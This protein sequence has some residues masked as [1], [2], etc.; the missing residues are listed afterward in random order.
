MSHCFIRSSSKN[1]S[2]EN[3]SAQKNRILPC[4]RTV[5]RN[6]QYAKRESV[7]SSIRTSRSAYNNIINNPN[8]DF[9]GITFKSIP[10]IHISNN[11]IYECLPIN[12]IVAYL[13]I[14]HDPNVFYIY[15]INN[16]DSFYI[17]NNIL[18]T[19]KIF[20]YD[21]NN[22]ENNN[23]DIH[24]IAYKC[25][26]GTFCQT[27]KKITTIKISNSQY[28]Q[29]ILSICD[30]E[31]SKEDDLL[32]YLK[33]IQRKQIKLLKS[34]QWNNFF[35][36][37]I[38]EGDYIT[39]TSFINNE[40]QIYKILITTIYVDQN[41][42]EYVI[43]NIFH[44][45]LL[46]TISIE[47]EF[48]ESSLLSITFNDDSNSLFNRYNQ[49]F[50]WIAENINGKYVYNILN[51]D[52]TSNYTITAND[53]GKNIVASVV[54]RNNETIVI[55]SKS[56][57]SP[58]ITNI[59]N[60]PTGI[61]KI[62]GY[63]NIGQYLNVNENISDLDGI[64]NKTITWYQG[65]KEYGEI[66]SVIY[67]W[68]I[69]TN[70]TDWEAIE[71]SNN[72]YFSIPIDDNYKNK[73]L[74]I[75]A[76]VY[77]IY[78]NKTI[79]YSSNVSD[80][81]KI[82]EEVQ[83]KVF[84]YSLQGTPLIGETLQVY[85]KDNNIMK[86]DN[87]TQ[88]IWYRSFNKVDWSV[89]TQNRFLPNITLP[90]SQE[91]LYLNNYIKAT[92]VVNDG[93]NI[94][95]YDTNSS[96]MITNYELFNNGTI[97]VS[98]K[99]LEG[100]KLTALL[101]T[102]ESINLDEY[103]VRYFWQTSRDN[104]MWKTLSTDDLYSLQELENQLSYVRTEENQNF[105]VSKDNKSMI[106]PSN[107]SFIDSVVR[108]KVLLTKNGITEYVLSNLTS[109]VKNIDATATGQVT[110]SGSSKL[111]T[112]LQSTV[113]DL[114][115]IDGPI[116]IKSYLWQIFSNEDTDNSWTNTGTNN[117][118]FDIP[119]DDSFIGKSI[120]L[121]LS[122]IDS[123][124]GITTLYSNILD[125]QK[126]DTTQDYKVFI[127]GNTI[128]GSTLSVI[129]D[130]SLKKENVIKYLW[131][132]SYDKEKVFSIVNIDNKDSI[133]IPKNNTYI[134]KYISVEIIYNNNNKIVN[135]TSPY[136]NRIIYLNNQAEST[137]Q[138]QGTSMLGQEMYAF[139]EGL[140]DQDNIVVD[141]NNKPFRGNQLYMD[142]K[143]LDVR[144]RTSISYTDNFGKYNIIYSDYSNYITDETEINPVPDDPCYF[145]T[146]TLEY[147]F[148]NSLND[149]R[150][151]IIGIGGI[152]NI[153]ED[154]ILKGRQR[155]VVD[156]GTFNI[157][158]CNLTILNFSQFLILRGGVF[159]IYGGNFTVFPRATYYIDNESFNV[160][161]DKP[162]GPDPKCTINSSINN[163]L[164]LSILKDCDIINI[165]LG[166][167]VT[168]NK[169]WIIES[170]KNIVINKFGKLIANNSNI[171]LQPNSS[172]CIY[173]EF[174]L[175]GSLVTHIDSYFYVDKF[176]VYNNSQ[177][178]SNNRIIINKTISY[179]EV[180]E[181]FK[182]NYEIVI[183]E[184]GNF[185]DDSVSITIESLNSLIVD[186]GGSVNL[187][188]CT[189]NIKEG[190]TFIINGI[191]NKING[192]L[193]VE[194]NSTFQFGENA[195]IVISL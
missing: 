2:N 191:F 68:Q 170:G 40:E 165:T 3:F 57:M 94:N 192:E 54:Y 47:G 14:K 19:S 126:N 105:V 164:F 99:S 104:I 20:R 63:P 153:T 52:N 9:H 114:E 131:K 73:Y 49:Y 194:I 151:V 128:E 62:L 183:G 102:D 86:Q 22:N 188:N 173:G 134:G 6:D 43:N 140:Y 178:I 184:N 97:T 36:G 135:Y 77:D 185:E 145:M 11:E 96:D 92:V 48:K 39:N 179:S 176:G 121:C 163:D 189:L 118:H 158:Y 167:I 66:T 195:S 55:R 193:N 93:K 161:D 84:K 159:N 101:S 187:N 106:I 146:D 168:L 150:H 175:T 171:I 174:E 138:L 90:I 7:D 98:G 95:Y 76:N 91:N 155:I 190:A 10:S 61:V 124:G 46:E 17:K 152:V 38:V 142:D 157:N 129:L 23:I 30:I 50:W 56:P 82:N 186:N 21:Y 122:S 65:K 160:I 103:D 143:Y 169:T 116:L 75:K 67:E 33:P 154:L 166:G 15:K 18:Y 180:E 5:F 182:N 100:S 172:L 88:Y 127:S 79:F 53:V 51:N 130:G 119:N 60:L 132:Y 107:G 162:F 113:T 156:G 85:D 89:I 109:K 133:L 42:K 27:I 115:D 144:F 41:D 31:Y 70:K 87:N 120:R 1:I 78:G 16:S 13:S 136:T 83:Q 28:I 110:I 69:S 34:I 123:R 45:K 71:H 80:S 111:N 24:L 108:C 59:D 141:E 137:L 35:N 112:T 26:K 72:K 139:F 125:I 29:N 37:N 8:S 181:Y 4:Q 44:K 177:Y 12:T 25:T 64:E 147:D 58:V 149:C 81:I 148:Y 117:S 32:S 74:R